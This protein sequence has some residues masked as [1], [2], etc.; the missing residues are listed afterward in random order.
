MTFYMMA[1]GIPNLLPTLVVVATFAAQPTCTGP[2]PGEDLWLVVTLS[3]PHAQEHPEVHQ[4]RLLGGLDG[5]AGA[6][7]KCIGELWG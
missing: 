6:V 3:V 2:A 1:P 4:G 7:S 5:E